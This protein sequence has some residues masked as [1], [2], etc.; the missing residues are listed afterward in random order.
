MGVAGDLIPLGGAALRLVNTAGGALSPGVARI[1]AIVKLV[2]C[3][4]APSLVETEL[5]GPCRIAEHILDAARTSALNAKLQELGFKFGDATT[6][7]LTDFIH[8]N[9][10]GSAF[11]TWL[12]DANVEHLAVI[13]KTGLEDL[14]WPVTKLEDLVDDLMRIPGLLAKM[15]KNSDLI[16]AWDVLSA[17]PL[18]RQN[19]VYLERL[20]SLG[21]DWANLK[22]SFANALLKGEEHV[23]KWME[24]KIPKTDL[25]KTYQN[26]LNDIPGEY[27]PFTP[28]HKAQRWEQYKLE[29]EAAGETPNYEA[30]SNKYDGNIDKAATSDKGLNDYYTSQGWTDPPYKKQHA[31]T[32]NIGPINTPSGEISGGRRFDIFNKDTGQAIEFKEYSEGIVYKTAD[33]EAEAYKDAWLVNNGKIS[34]AK[35]IFKNCEPSGPLKALLMEL[36]LYP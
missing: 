18:F 12:K 10:L 30:W 33:I 14:K 21:F 29:K 15:A 3:Q 34:S 24:L 23:R 31:W 1:I 6:K 20:A 28:E 22:S 5:L 4:G 16:K 17:S 7:L 13:F 2:P 32:D 26:G 11:H 25:E 36:N 9:R 35:W 27:T 8:N 19:E